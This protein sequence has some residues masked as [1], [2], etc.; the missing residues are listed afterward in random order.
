MTMAHLSLP[1][2]FCCRW[3]GFIFLMTAASSRICGGEDLP[4]GLQTFAKELESAM[5]SATLSFIHRRLDVR[6]IRSRL[7]E[8]AGGNASHPGVRALMEQF[9]TD[10]AFSRHLG[11]GQYKWLNARKEGEVW[12]LAFRGC[13]LSDGNVIYFDWVVHQGEFWPWEIVDFHNYFSGSLASS[14]AGQAL[15]SLSDFSQLSETEGFRD[16]LLPVLQQIAAATRSRQPEDLAEGR[17][18]YESLPP[19]VRKVSMVRLLGKML[20]QQGTAGD[21]ID[22]AQVHEAPLQVFQQALAKG[23]KAMALEALAIVR[24]WTGNDIALGWL[25]GE[26]ALCDDKREEAA[27]HYRKVLQQEPSFLPAWLR[28]WVQPMEDSERKSLR[29]EFVK[30]F[31]DEMADRLLEAPE[32]E[33][34]QLIGLLKD[35]D[36]LDGDMLKSLTPLLPN[37]G[38]RQDFPLVKCAFVSWPDEGWK[39]R[40]NPEL[41]QGGGVAGVATQD[42]PRVMFEFAIY[43]TRPDFRLDDSPL[44]E[45]GKLELR[46]A[47]KQSQLELVKEAKASVGGRAAVRL[48]LKQNSGFETTFQD[49]WVVPYQSQMLMISVTASKEEILDNDPRFAVYATSLT[50]DEGEEPAGDK[51]LSRE[52]LQEFFA[53]VGLTVADWPSSEEWETKALTSGFQSYLPMATTL[54]ITASRSTDGLAVSLAVSENQGEPVAATGLAADVMIEAMRSAMEA[55][56]GEWV[57]NAVI[58]VAERPSFE[59]WSRIKTAAR[60]FNRQ[61]IVPGI[62][63]NINVNINAS[64]T[65]ALSDPALAKMLNSLRWTETAPEEGLSSG[66]EEINA[67]LRLSDLEILELPRGWAAVTMPLEEARAEMGD[68]V[69]FAAALAHSLTETFAILFVLEAADAEREMFKP[70]VGGL[71]MLGMR[72][73]LAADGL[74]LL[75]HEP[76]ELDSHHGLDYIVENEASAEFTR[77]LQIPTDGKIFQITVSG[78]SADAVKT[79]EVNKLMRCVRSLRSDK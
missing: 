53:K 28:L 38:R 58:E 46:M 41:P 71:T 68:E 70:P 12:R 77:I 39:T 1:Y 35:M 16:D 17:E 65:A 78:L 54:A 33:A 29:A 19:A 76:V 15:G 18:L 52:E 56:G 10:N 55:D 48:R 20:Y 26:L 32:T 4:A 47:L 66:R 5:S 23:D 7:N 22:A 8:S 37:K 45:M 59:I 25:E 50:F 2:P 75:S 36:M 24:E 42:N 73:Q 13:T 21:S 64:T 27:A 3:L 72:T 62:K 63:Y 67:A 31:D 79:E 43:P 57:R 34:E 30:H 40:I 60:P 51:P 44:G 49:R 74:K 61:L 69:L 11:P 14:L 9:E 6:E